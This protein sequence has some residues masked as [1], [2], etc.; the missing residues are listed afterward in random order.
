LELA[1]ISYIDY[2]EAGFK[3]E[4]LLKL[5]DFLQTREDLHWIQLNPK[6]GIFELI[7]DNQMMSTFRK[8]PAHFMLSYV[9]VLELRRA[10]RAWFL[11]YG[12]LFHKMIEI[13]YNI[14]RNPDFDVIKWAGQRAILE[15]D[16]AEMDFHKDHKEY[17]S[18]GGIHGFCGLLVAYAAKFSAENE[19]CR[20][21]GTEISFGKGREV[22]LGSV[23][24]F[25]NCF[26]SG[27]ADV[28]IDDGTFICPMDHKTMASFRNDPASKYEIDEGPTGYIYAVNQILPKLV[29]EELLLKRSCNRIMM[30]YISKASTLIPSDRFRRLP[31]YK[32]VEQ[33]ESYRQRMLLTGENIFRALV[34]Y[35]NTGFAVRD[36]SNCTSWFMHDCP[37]TPIHRQG[38][39]R[40][41][42][43]IISSMYQKGKIWNTEEV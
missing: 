28:L 43:A 14:F 5:R 32:T 24:G 7:L 23:G 22:P 19:R 6:T 10:G 36:T 11:D 1:S 13:Y 16:L 41:E 17:K 26:L 9:D 31:I 37:Y 25:L 3:A 20:V 38:S 4:Q 27:R 30:N 42:L 12:I 29:P 33:L 21:I 15:W 34:A 2:R 35:V 39:S 8:C 40:D 18:T